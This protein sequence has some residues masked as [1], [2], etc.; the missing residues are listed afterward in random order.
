[1]QYIWSLGPID[2]DGPNLTFLQ[3]PHRTIAIFLFFFLC[4]PYFTFTRQDSRDFWFSSR[5][6]CPRLFSP[7]AKNSRGVLY[8]SFRDFRLPRLS[9]P[10]DGWG[11]RFSETQFLFFSRLLWPHLFWF[12]PAGTK[13]I[14]SGVQ[15]YKSQSVPSRLDKSLELWFIICTVI[16]GSTYKIWNDFEIPGICF[17]GNLVGNFVTLSVSR[18][19]LGSY[20]HSFSQNIFHSLQ[21]FW[22]IGALVNHWFFWGHMWSY[23]CHFGAS[24]AP[25]TTEAIC[26]V[27]F[28]HV[29]DLEP[30]W[31]SW[32]HTW[33]HRME[34]IFHTS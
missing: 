18:V 14:K 32:G 1:M 6:L 22:C 25:G 13:Q 28:G 33:G 23:E 11:E 19:S 7:A 3:A 24:K 30:P 29:R 8:F 16:L 26:V 17:L 27:M 4:F 10:V 20:Y 2:E 12:Y 31:I 34:H 21:Y 5:L 9:L 15:F